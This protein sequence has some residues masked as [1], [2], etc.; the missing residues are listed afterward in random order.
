MKRIF[1]LFAVL[2]VAVFVLNGYMTQASNQDSFWAEAAQGGMAEV[3][4]ANLALQ[5]SQ[6]EEVKKM[7]QMM[8]DDHTKAS[9]EL[10]PLAMS[11]NVMLPAAMDSKHQSMMSKMSGMSGAEFDMMYVK[12]MVKDHEKAVSMFQKES[13]GGKDADA[14]AFATKQLPV[15]QEH[16]TMA[17]SMMNGMKKGGG[18][19]NGKMSGM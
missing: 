17:Q 5:K 18:M 7:A 15:L 1:A 19:S 6:N 2:V 14:K 11:K 12:A 3:A 16:L 13:T 9:E 8:I 4:L 10:K